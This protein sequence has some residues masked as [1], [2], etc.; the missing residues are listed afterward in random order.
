MDLKNEIQE[1]LDFLDSCALELAQIEKKEKE[2]V[3]QL[4]AALDKLATAREIA[5]QKLTDRVVTELKGLGFS[6]HVQVQF[7]FQP[8]ELYPGLSEMR[9]RLMWIPNPGQAAQPLDKIASG[10]ELSRF[11][12][13]ITGLQGESENRP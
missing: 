5:A 12:L 6:E 1:N 9:G 3:E 10:G 2:L 7:E 13:A 11:L 8:H 4:S